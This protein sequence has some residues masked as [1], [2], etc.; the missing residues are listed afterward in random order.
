MSG[1][2]VRL[3]GTTDAGGICHREVPGQSPASP[4]ADVRRGHRPA[5]PPL[6]PIPRLSVH[7]S[8]HPVVAAR[9]PVLRR[10]LLAAHDNV[11]ARRGTTYL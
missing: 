8:P 9:P 1:W 10:R 5:S 11:D 3:S 2:M 4:P 6:S 7:P